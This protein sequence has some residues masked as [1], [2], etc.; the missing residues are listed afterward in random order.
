MEEATIRTSNHLTCTYDGGFLQKQPQK[1]DPAFNCSV[2]E[3][4]STDVFAHMY[5]IWWYIDVCFSTV[6]FLWWGA[7]KS[8]KP[9]FSLEV[10]LLDKKHHV[11]DSTLDKLH[12]YEYVGFTRLFWHRHSMLHTILN[13][14][15]FSMMIYMII[16]YLYYIDHRPPDRIWIIKYLTVTLEVCQ[17]IALNAVAVSCWALGSVGGTR[18]RTCGGFVQW[19]TATDWWTGGENG[20]SWVQKLKSVL[21]AIYIKSHI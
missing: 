8:W 11:S 16:L 7:W 15:S 17:M 9:G 5:T 20:A 10:S 13:H 21:Y 18:R 3:Y 2:W 6:C 4:M 19:P 1:S 14:C 12:R